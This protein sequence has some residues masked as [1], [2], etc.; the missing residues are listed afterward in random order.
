VSKG[1]RLGAT[2]LVVACLSFAALSVVVFFTLEGLSERSRLEA[3]NDMER[4]MNILLASLRDHDDFGQAIEDSDR[5]KTKVIGVG[6]YGKG[7]AELYSWGKV[8]RAFIAA[9]RSLEGPDNAERGYIDKPEND[10]IVLLLLPMRVVPPPPDV[11]GPPD[12]GLPP[13]ME[14]RAPRDRG[15]GGE[16]APRMT[17]NSPSIAAPL[18]PEHAFL[19]ETLKKSDVVYL[20]IRESAFWRTKRFLAALFPFTEVL[21]AALIVFVRTLVMRNAEYRKRIEEQ[22]SLVILGTAASTLAHEVKNPLLAIRLQT[23]ILE[24]TCPDA[25]GEIGI[26]NDEV[27]RIS[28]LCFRVNDYLRDP[29]GE[30]RATDPEELAREVGK[31][32]CGRDILTTRREASRPPARIMIDPARLTSILENVLRN[33]LES[34]SPETEVSI[35]MGEAEGG[36]YLD[37]LD[38]GRGIRKADRDR[39]FDPFFTTK[40]RG[41]GI[42]LSICRRFVL[43]AK[44]T[45]SLDE[46]EGGGTRVRISFPLA[47]NLRK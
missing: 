3:R 26:I 42:G 40:S 10:S 47:E 30:R 16:R 19:F 21:L 32:L 14:P 37:V 36:L 17:M 27:D 43:A 24:R 8:P 5:L 6:V 15:P 39:L 28:T 2:S 4:T 45:I 35:E 34:G 7:G 29:A 41:S 11:K 12:G 13:L 18:R 44:G 23:G 25:G 38:R 46:R 33:A 22:K 20:E 1:P 31:R 9:S